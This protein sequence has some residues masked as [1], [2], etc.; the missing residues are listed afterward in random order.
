[1]EHGSTM[2]LYNKTKHIMKTQNNNLNLNKTSLVELNNK[3][4]VDVNGG[5]TTFFVDWLQRKI[6]EATEEMTQWI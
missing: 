1:M 6:D 2:A 5:S 4:M 3:E